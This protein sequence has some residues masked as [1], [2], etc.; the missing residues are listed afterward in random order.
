MFSA[1]DDELVA[2]TVTGAGGYYSFTGLD[3][4]ESYWV[5]VEEGTVPAGLALTTVGVAGTAGTEPLYLC[6]DEDY[7]DADF[8]YQPPPPHI[9]VGGEARPVDRL[10]ILARWILSLAAAIMP[11]G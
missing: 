6:C 9:E 2:S 7:E 8:G 5:E 1:L 10:A 3:C 11:G 4:W